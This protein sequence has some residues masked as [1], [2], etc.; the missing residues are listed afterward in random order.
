MIIENIGNGYYAGVMKNLDLIVV[1][2]KEYYLD[3]V[4]AS[5]YQINNPRLEIIKRLSEVAFF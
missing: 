1:R 4:F 2:G 5:C 3:P